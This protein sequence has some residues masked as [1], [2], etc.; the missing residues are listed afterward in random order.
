MAKEYA[1]YPFDYMCITQRYDQGNHIPHWKNS[2]NYSDKPWDEACKDSGR[3]YF[4]P[5]N[6]YKLILNNQF[7]HKA[8][9]TCLLLVCS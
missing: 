7:Y 8:L 9:S 1:V 6:D 5:Q 3:S 2:K 4:I